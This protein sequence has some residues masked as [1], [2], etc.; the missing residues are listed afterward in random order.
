MSRTN[1]KSNI[2]M[3]CPNLACRATVCAPESTR[4]KLARCPTCKLIFRVPLP[5]ASPAPEPATPD[6]A[7]TA[8]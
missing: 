1:Q 6:G 8:R 2:T 5:P 4:G 3:I 7:P